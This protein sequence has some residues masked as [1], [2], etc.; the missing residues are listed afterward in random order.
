MAVLWLVGQAHGWALVCGGPWGGEDRAGTT[1][2]PW[3]R[4][5]EPLS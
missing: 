5:P 4:T 1:A 2:G 3:A